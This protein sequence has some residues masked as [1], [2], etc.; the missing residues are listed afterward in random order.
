M[1]ASVAFLITASGKIMSTTP[2]TMTST[3]RSKSVV[4]NPA[5]RPVWTT[6]FSVPAPKTSHPGERLKARA[7]LVRRALGSET[8]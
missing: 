6:S 3:E 7:E 5:A 4:Q 8:Y 1:G 2:Q